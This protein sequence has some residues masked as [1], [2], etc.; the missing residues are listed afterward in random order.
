MTN[1]ELSSLAWLPNLNK[2]WKLKLSDYNFW[3][4][5]SPG[6]ETSKCSLQFE[7]KQNQRSFCHVLAVVNSAVL[8]LCC[9][10]LFNLGHFVLLFP[11]VGLLGPIC[12]CCSVTKLCLALCNPMNCSKP[13]FPV[14]HY[15]PEFAQ[16]H[17][18]W[19]GVAVQP[20]H[21]LPPPPPP[22]NLSQRHCLFQWVISLHQWPKY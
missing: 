16:T 19:V 14:L 21:P 4:L 6:R 9:I 8:R 3:R 7:W 1:V 2:L 17:A 22:L 5:G 12:C 10:Y 20:S 18:H 11:G 13:G 15:L